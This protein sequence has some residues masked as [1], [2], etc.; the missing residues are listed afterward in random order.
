MLAATPCSPW[1]G[2]RGEDD[3]DAPDFGA[4]PKAGAD[5][6]PGSVGRSSNGHALANGGP[7]PA[8]ARRKT[9]PAR[10][11]KPVLAADQ[12]AAL[13]DRLAAALDALPSADEAATSASW[14]LPAKNTPTAADAELVEAGFRARP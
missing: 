5:Q 6:P 10:P 1:S 2:S 12:S 8:G 4:A 7:A 11:A 13:R 9:P 3:L 14:S